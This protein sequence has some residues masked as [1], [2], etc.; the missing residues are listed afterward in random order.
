MYE[1][2]RIVDRE[3]LLKQMRIFAEDSKHYLS[4]LSNTT[5]LLKQYYPQANWIGFYFRIDDYLYLGPFQ[6]N[7]ACQYLSLDQGV[8]GKAVREEKTQIVKDVHELPYH[9]AC[10][11][12]SRSEIVIPIIKNDKVWGVLDLDAPTLAYFDEDDRDM[13][14]ELIT[15]LKPYLTEL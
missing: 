6:G 9:V 4:L 15:I 5:A 12:D 14:E 1:H 3:L 7:S 10:D 13:L 2:E 8:C 11:A